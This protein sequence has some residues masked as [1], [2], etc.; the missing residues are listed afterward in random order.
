MISAFTWSTAQGRPDEG[1][2]KFRCLVRRIKGA[3]RYGKW[4]T[5]GAVREDRDV[6][7]VECG[8]ASTARLCAPS[9][10]PLA[11]SP[12]AEGARWGDRAQTLL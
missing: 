3:G 2:L 8:R 1:G 11:R 6:A 4:A 5:T 10:A 12:T 7:G 9:V